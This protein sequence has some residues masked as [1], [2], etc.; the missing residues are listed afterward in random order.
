[1]CVPPDQTNELIQNQLLGWIGLLQI[2][3]CGHVSG[4]RDDYGHVNGYVVQ[5]R[6]GH[7]CGHARC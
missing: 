3:S 4:Q 6:G 7:V 1:M 2:C 5:S